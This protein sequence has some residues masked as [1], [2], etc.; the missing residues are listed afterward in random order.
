MC[1]RIKKWV[2][3]SISAKRVKWS[4]GSQTAWIWARSDYIRAKVTFHSKQMTFHSKKILRGFYMI[5]LTM[6]VM[7]EAEFSEGTIGFMSNIG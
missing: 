3:K 5:Y 6:T 1:G 4:Y 2:V 7:T